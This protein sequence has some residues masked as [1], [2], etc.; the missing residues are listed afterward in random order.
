MKEKESQYKQAMEVKHSTADQSQQAAKIIEDLQ[1]QN[2]KLQGLLKASAQSATLERNKTDADMT[3]H[4][5]F[6]RH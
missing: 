1:L 6:S 5:V 3:L 4:T 2:S